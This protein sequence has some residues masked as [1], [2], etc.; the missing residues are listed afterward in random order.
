MRYGQITPR[1]YNIVLI[2]VEKVLERNVSR[3]LVAITIQRLLTNNSKIIHRVYF[4]RYFLR[5]KRIKS[6]IIKNINASCTDVTT[7]YMGSYVILM[8]P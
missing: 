8:S 5:I 2:P 4:V 3:V 1:T 7:K 6:T